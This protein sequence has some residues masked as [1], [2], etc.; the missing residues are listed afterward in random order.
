MVVSQYS[1][2]FKVIYDIWLSVSLCTMILVH[3]M[4]A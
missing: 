2:E 1:K 3:M 4:M